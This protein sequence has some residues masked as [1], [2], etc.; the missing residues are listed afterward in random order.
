[1]EN[2][3]VT[4]FREEEFEVHLRLEGVGWLS[5][6]NRHR[7]A[8]HGQDVAPAQLAGK[9]VRRVTDDA[10]SISIEFDDDTV[11]TIDLDTS[12]YRGPEALVLE[13]PGAPIVV[14]N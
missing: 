11:I 4:S 14:V 12:A 1:M 7:I 3:E 8:R 10:K 5:I 13:L 6:Y 9:R 2:L